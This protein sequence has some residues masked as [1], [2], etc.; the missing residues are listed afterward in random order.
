MVTSSRNETDSVFE[1]EPMSKHPYVA[2][3]EVRSTKYE[4]FN[5]VVKGKY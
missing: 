3:M 1:S 4:I 5:A 2:A